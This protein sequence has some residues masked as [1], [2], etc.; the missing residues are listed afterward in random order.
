MGTMGDPR[1]KTKTGDEQVKKKYTFKGKEITPEVAEEINRV[2]NLEDKV[3]KLDD[4]NKKLISMCVH[5]TMLINEREKTIESL[6]DII[7]TQSVAIEKFKHI[8]GRL[9]WK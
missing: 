7:R 2:S 3:G 1:K 5:R 6:K 8:F 4:E 9:Y